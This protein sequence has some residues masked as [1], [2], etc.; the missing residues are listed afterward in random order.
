MNLLPVEAFRDFWANPARRS[1]GYGVPGRIY[2]L[3]YHIGEDVSGLGGDSDAVPILRSGV[4]VESS[5]ASK[6]GGYFAVKV[7]GDSFHDIY[8]HMRY[9]TTP[10]VGDQVVVRQNGG[11]LATADDPVADR[12][13]DSD[14]EHCHFVQSRLSSGAWNVLRGNDRDPNP[15]INSA[16]KALATAASDVE[17]FEPAPEPEPPAPEEGAMFVYRYTCLGVGSYL[18][19]ATPGRVETVSVPNNAAFNAFQWQL[20]MLADGF[21]RKDPR[22]RDANGNLIVSGIPNETKDFTYLKT[23]AVR[24]GVPADFDILRK[25][26]LSAPAVSPSTGGVGGLTAADLA[27][28]DALDDDER[29]AQT[30]TILQAIAA[31][32]T[33]LMTAISNVDEATLATFGLKRA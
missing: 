28:I 12:G 3:G 13:T 25:P 33:S 22:Q 17:G 6:I 15:S 2:S 18:L 23:M 8:C 7:P 26:Y 21:G 10:N 24:L 30:A 11:Q 27:A 14:G 32:D 9:S 1:N 20:N 5:R 31:G 29:A 16:L 4:V 19:L